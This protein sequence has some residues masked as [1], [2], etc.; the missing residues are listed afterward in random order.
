MYWPSV[1]QNTWSGECKP[2]SSVFLGIQRTDKFSLL[3]G[4]NSRAALIMTEQ[5]WMAKN[6]PVVWLCVLFGEIKKSHKNAL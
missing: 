5:N 6:V 1:G 2:P 3:I 4:K